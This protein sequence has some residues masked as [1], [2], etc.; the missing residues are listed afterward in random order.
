MRKRRLGQINSDNLVI[1]DGINPPFHQP[2]LNEGEP[3]SELEFKENI[4]VINRKIV[5]HETLGNRSNIE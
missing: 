1:E 2:M 4:V 3:E 5:K